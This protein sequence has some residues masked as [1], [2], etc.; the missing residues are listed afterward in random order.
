MGCDIHL[1]TEVKI[2]G[3]WQHYGFPR[4]LRN[5]SVFAKM[6]NV[7]NEYR[8]DDI[9]PISLPKGIPEDATE[10]T[11]YSYEYWKEDAHSMSWLDAGEIE[12]LEDYIN[13]ELKPTTATNLIGWWCEENWGYLFG[14]SWG[15]FTK[16]PENRPVGL[17]D[18]RFVFWF[19]N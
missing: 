12:Q 6:A 13:K 2:N 14:N 16:Y 17:E 18:I 15:G 5:Y 4:V 8:E 11:K 1:H 19:D 10:L 7:R 3:K 9:T